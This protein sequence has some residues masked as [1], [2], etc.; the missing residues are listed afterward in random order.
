MINIYAPGTDNW[1]NN[2]LAILLPTSCKI[3]ETAG[4][5]YELELTHPITDDLRWKTIAEGCVIKAP[6]PAS[7]T[8][9]INLVKAGIPAVPEIPAIPGN[10]GTPA[11][12]A[13]EPVPGRIIWRVHITT[14]GSGGRSRIYERAHAGSK[15][16]AYLGEGQ[17]YEYLGAYNG[18]WHR[19]VNS[20][21]ISGYMYTP[22]SEYV[23]TEAATGGRA[24]VAAIPPTPGVPGVPGIPAVP[25]YST[26]VGPRQIRTQLF[27]VYHVEM[28]T[29][30]NTVKVWARHISYDFMGNI[31]GSLKLD[32]VPMPIA[33]ERLKASM[34]TTETRDLVTN[35]PDTISGEWQYENGIKVLLDP[36]TGFVAKSRCKIIRDN[37]DIFLLDNIAYDRRVKVEY[38]KNLNGIKWT[39]RSDAVVTRIVPVGRKA[40]NTNLLLPETYVD[41]EYISIYPVVYTQKLDVPDAKVSD[42]MTTEQAYT[43]MRNAAAAEFAKGCDLVSFDLDV[44]FIQLGDTEEYK[45]FHD[46]QQVF[47]YDTITITHSPT[48]LSARAQVKAYEWDAILNKYTKVTLGDVFEAAGGGIAGYQLPTGGIAGTKLVPGGVGS[49]QLRSLSVLSAHIG[50]AQVKTAN[51]GLAVVEKANIANLAVG[52]A[53]IED[54]AVETAKIKDAAITS[55]KIGEA[56][57]LTANIKDAAITSAKIYD[58][59]ITNAKIGTG[60]ITYLKL[61]QGIADE[62]KIQTAN[63][64]NGV[65]TNAQ[66]ADA[67][68]ETAKIIDGA[69]TTAKIEDAAIVTAKIEDAAITSAKIDDLAVN[70]AK[71]A[72]AAIG[73]A[74]ID[75]L[76]VGTANIQLGAITTA[77]IGDEAVQTAQIADASITDAKIVELTANKITAGQLSVE[78]LIISGNDESIMFAINN[79]G[80]LESTSVDSLDGAVMTPR[81]ITA[82]RIVAESITTAEIASETILAN[83]I[84]ANAVTADKIAAGSVDANKIA[85][86]SIE[87]SHLAPQFGNQIV[88]AENPAVVNAFNDIAA[89]IIRATG[90]EDTIK[91][92]TDPASGFFIFDLESST[93]TIGRGDSPFR[94]EFSNTK[95]A[96]KQAG[97]EVAYISNNKLYISIG[98]IMH[99]LTIGEKSVASGGEGFVDIITKN[100]GQRAVWRAN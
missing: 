41:S 70:R 54:A 44:D 66:I 68:I 56:Q 19:A 30:A 96:F 47:L 81:S 62:L 34:I 48:N 63:I 1:A 43:V 67:T 79:A 53:Q 23:R 86:G 90:V 64:G 38:G 24:A 18:N 31:C 13:V 42:T 69:I 2:G 6:V 40:D 94:S 45:Q 49:D 7:E 73:T 92:F 75:D 28:D 46:L 84:A 72:L 29:A 51:I 4:G 39:K 61:Y 87:T 35:M 27:R 21:G 89:E 58:G 10:P 57:I 3:S 93:M 14:T 33:C 99:M 9:A 65:I 37:N 12:P 97:T 16:L 91:T 98:Q 78:R 55:A 8:P 76:A 88:I 26:V 22:N 5:S 59:S 95:L 82:D 52:T 60:E 74:Q 100:G 85:A 83:N 71:I 15:A 36:E 50:L 11:I 17:E 25:G 32:N 20:A 80:E 77:L